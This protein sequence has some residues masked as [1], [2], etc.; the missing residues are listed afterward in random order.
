MHQFTHTHFCTHVFNFAKIILIKNIY[1]L[2]KIIATG[3]LTQI[4][5]KRKTTNL[6][7]TNKGPETSRASTPIV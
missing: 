1:A 7:G 3:I 6:M 4:L 5:T 2:I